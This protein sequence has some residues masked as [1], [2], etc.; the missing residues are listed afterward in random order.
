MP[1]HLRGILTVPYGNV[2]TNDV[3][4]GIN[5]TSLTT[6]LSTLATT[7]TNAGITATTALTTTT[8]ILA[9]I[10]TLATIT[11][12]DNTTSSLQPLD[13]TGTLALLPKN[14]IATNTYFSS[15]PKDQP[16]WTS[17]GGATS[18]NQSNATDGNFQLLNFPSV[19]STL[20]LTVSNNCPSQASI[21][22]VNVKVGN[23]TGF[24]L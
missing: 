24:T 14:I 7:A 5:S 12:V 23:S 3:L 18:T 11:Y 13:I 4:Y 19:G 10:P 9:T 15:F 8:S 1:G 17:T 2:I 20:T 6:A 21:F 22:S 16:T